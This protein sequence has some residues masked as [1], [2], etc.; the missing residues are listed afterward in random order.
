GLDVLVIDELGFELAPDAMA[1]ESAVA[2]ER[3][4]VV[5]SKLL[6]VK[7]PELAEPRQGVPGRSAGAKLLLQG[8]PHFG[9]RV[10]SAGRHAGRGLQRVGFFNC[11]QNAVPAVSRRSAGEPPTLREK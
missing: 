2:G 6:V 4:G 11:S 5:P 9:D 3:G 1:S 8:A 10:R 7:I